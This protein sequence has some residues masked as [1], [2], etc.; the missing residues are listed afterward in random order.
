VKFLIIYLDGLQF[1]DR[2]LIGAVWLEKKA[3]STS[4]AIRERATENATVDKEI[5][6]ALVAREVNPERKRL[7]V[8]DRSKALRAA[9]NAVFGSQCPVQRCRSPKLRN[10]LDHLPSDQKSAVRSVLRA[11]WRL[12]AQ[13]GRAKVKKL[14]EWLEREYPSAADGLREGLEECFTVNGLEVLASLHH[15]LTITNIIGSPQSDVRTRTRRVCRWRSGAMVK[16]RA[17]AAF[18]AT[19]RAF[20]KLW[21]SRSLDVGT[22]SSTDRPRVTQRRWRSKMFQPPPSNSQLRWGPPLCRRAGVFPYGRALMVQAAAPWDVPDLAISM[23]EEIRV[24]FTVPEQLPAPSAAIIVP[25]HAM[26]GHHKLVEAWVRVKA[27]ALQLATRRTLGKTG[28][29]GIRLSSLEVISVARRSG[30][31]AFRP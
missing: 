1:G 15:C 11:A 21:V 19:E 16:R 27:F 12:D 3:T 30:A 6:E 28:G 25:T 23:V 9:V 8:H 22:R 13:T 2:V 18:R 31:P 17:A 10:A 20:A 24:K 7:L 5:L 26:N 14:A 4:L 29:C